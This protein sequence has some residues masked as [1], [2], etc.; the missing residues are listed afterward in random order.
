[1]SPS[2]TNTVPTSKSMTLA[3]LY[4]P[5]LLDHCCLL[6]SIPLRYC[7]ACVA[8]NPVMCSDIC[9]TMCSAARSAICGAFCHVFCRVFCSASCCVSSAVRLPC[10]LRCVLL[11][12]LRCI[13]RC[14]L[15][16]LLPCVHCRGHA[17]GQLCVLRCVLRCVLQCLLPCVHCRGH[18]SG[19]VLSGTRLRT[20]SVGDTPPDTK[21]VSPTCAAHS[22][23]EQPN[24]FLHHR[25]NQYIHSITVTITCCCRC[26]PEA[27]ICCSP[28]TRCRNCHPPCRT[29]AVRTVPATFCAF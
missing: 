7:F 16:C 25:C 24:R 26:R 3:L 5:A 21:S 27:C 12:V 28:G 8:M 1:M 11:C 20:C 23:H 2:L 6:Q 4:C 14:V 22:L 29:H 19:H 15:Q 10:V 18:A 9:F 13:L 17:S